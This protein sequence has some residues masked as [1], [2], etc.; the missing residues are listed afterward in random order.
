MP[1][2][3]KNDNDNE[4]EPSQ[5]LTP[6]LI[7]PAPRLDRGGRPA[8]KLDPRQVE[9]LCQVHATDE[10]IAAHFNISERTLY[11]MKQKPFWRKLFDRGRADGRI[12]LRRAQWRE[13]LRGSPSML[14]WLGK[15]LLGQ[16]ER[17]DHASALPGIET[18]RRLLDNMSE[19]D[20]ERLSK[21]YGMQNA[22]INIDPQPPLPSSRQI[23]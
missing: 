9:A 18:M 13:A 19:A 2:D 8:V 7:P 22:V 3:R 20:L 11:R 15:Q 21:D 1:K 16:K 6:E 17:Y 5:I 10:E 4:I 12:S 14:I 23:Q